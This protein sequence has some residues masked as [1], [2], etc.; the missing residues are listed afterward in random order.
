MKCSSYSLRLFL[1]LFAGLIV[2]R[3]SPAS[4][5]GDVELPPYQPDRVQVGDEAP[6]FTLPDI[7]GTPVSLSDF[8][9]SHLVVLT[10]YRGHW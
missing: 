3:C 10:F 9:G 1:V 2:S 6:D 8:R 7:D 5:S 4:D